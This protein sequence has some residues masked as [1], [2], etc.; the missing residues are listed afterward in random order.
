M[1]RSEKQKSKCDNS[2][3]FV[4]FGKKNG[5][6]LVLLALRYV[7]SFLKILTSVLEILAK[8]AEPVQMELIHTRASALVDSL[9]RLAG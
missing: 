5:V 4:C 1:A 3:L 9:V 2:F 8:M 6:I 7:N